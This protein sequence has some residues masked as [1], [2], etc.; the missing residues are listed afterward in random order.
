MIFLNLQNTESWVSGNILASM[1]KISMFLAIVAAEKSLKTWLECDPKPEGKKT[2][3]PR[4]LHLIIKP[5]MIFEARFVVFK[6]LG[7]AVQSLTCSSW[8]YGALCCGRDLYLCGHGLLKLWV[9]GSANDNRMGLWLP[10]PNSPSLPQKL[11]GRE[12]TA[13]NTHCKLGYH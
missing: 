13:P 7:F 9:L 8:I 1:L 5:F 2:K 10:L 6:H 3:N 4:I 11:R 12:I